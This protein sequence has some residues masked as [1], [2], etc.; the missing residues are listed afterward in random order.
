FL[1]LL[2]FQFHIMRK[3]CLIYM[4]AVSHHIPLS[5]RSE[6]IA[7]V[8]ALPLLPPLPPPPNTLHTPVPVMVNLHP[9][10]LMMDTAMA[11]WFKE[12]LLQVH[13][14]TQITLFISKFLRGCQ[15]GLGNKQMVLQLNINIKH[16]LNINKISTSRTSTSRTSTS[17][18][19]TSRT[20]TNRA[21]TNR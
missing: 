17:R 16:R 10:L 9:Q 1:L 14:I 18:T 6:S 3:G 11:Q 15:Q 13:K 19:S 21:S 8:N 12:T 5:S 4:H 20:S 7:M 2:Q